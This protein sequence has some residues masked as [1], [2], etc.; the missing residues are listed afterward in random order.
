MSKNK[1]SIGLPKMHLEPGEQRVF[2]PDFVH[3]LDELGADIVLE[4]GYGQ[5]GEVS[6]QC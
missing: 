3:N 1:F 4:N 6:G 2:L 5:A